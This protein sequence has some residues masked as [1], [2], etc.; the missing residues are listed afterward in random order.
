MKKFFLM[1]LAVVG[2]TMQANAIKLTVVAGDKNDPNNN[3]GCQKLVDGNFA[4]KWGDGISEGQTK[5]IIVKSN[6]AII[7][8]SYV[9]VT[10]NDTGGSPGRNWNVWK[11]YAGN[12]ASDADAARDAEGWVLIDQRADVAGTDQLPAADSQA[13]PSFVL[14]ETVTDSYLYYKIE[15]E[16]C[17]DL[18]TY[19]QMGE[20]YFDSYKV[21][22]SAF[23][24]DIAAANSFDYKKA[25]D[26]LLEAEYET[27]L[28][29]LNASED[30]D[31]VDALLTKIANVKNFINTQA[32]KEFY[33]LGGSNTWGDGGWSNFVDGKYDTKWGGGLG[34]GMWVVFRVRG[35]VQPFVYRLVTGADTKSYWDRNW[36]TWTVY[37]AN[38]KSIS[39]VSENSDQW[40][41]LDVRED[42]GQDLFPAENMNPTTF[43]FTEGVNEPYY[44]FK[45]LVT[46]C[47]NNGG[48]QQMSEIE[49]L[50]KE[51]LDEQK[52]AYL[53]EYA[54]VDLNAAVEPWHEAEKA[55]FVDAYNQL[56]ETNDVL[57]MS[58]LNNTLASLKSALE[59]SIA[60]RAA[61]EERYAN[62]GYL[63]LAGNTAWGNGENW[64]R[65]IDQNNS[66]KWGGGRDQ[67][68]AF[69]IFTKASSMAPTFYTLITG[70]DTAGDPSRN[71]ADWKIY[72]ANFASAAEATRDAEGWVLIDNKEGIGQDLLPGA[73]FAPAY[74]SMS[75][76]D[77]QEYSYFKIEISK[78]FND[79]GNIQMSEF[80]FGTDTE[81]AAIKAG[82]VEE[83]TPFLNGIYAD[84]AMTL[85]YN[86]SLRELT[87]AAPE[88]ILAKVAAVKAVQQEIL[89]AQP[90][91]A[92]VDGVYQI[93]SAGDLVTFA[94]LVNNAE[95]P[96]VGAKAV[97]TA[98]ID[99]TGVP[100]TYI[101]TNGN[102]AGTFDGQGYA[103]KNMTIDERD[104]S[105]IG[106]FKT[107]EGAT[108]TRVKLV[109]AFVNGNNNAGG[110]VGR[111]IN[112][113]ITKC[114]VVDSYVEGRDHVGS[115]AGEIR[116]D[117]GTTF[118]DN[119]SNS[120][121][122]SREYQAGGMIGTILGGLVEHNLFT[123]KVTCVY[124]NGT[125]LVA[126]VDG[127][128]SQSILR[129][130]AIFATSI[131]A[132]DAHSLTNTAGRPCTFQ[133]NYSLDKCLYNGGYFGLTNPDDQ[134]GGQVDWA[135]ATSRAFYSD[136]LGFD[137]AQTWTFNYGG[138]Y[139][140]P[141]YI[142]YD[143]PTK[144]KVPVTTAGY[145]T[146]VAPADV[147]FS[148]AEGV[149]AFYVTDGGS[150]NKKLEPATLVRHGEAVV[151]KAQVEESGETAETGATVE[152]T[153]LTLTN[154][155]VKPGTQTVTIT[156]AELGYSNTDKVGSIEFDGGIITF[157]KGSNS[158]AP[159]Y[160]TSGNA[161]RV[162]GDNTVK[163]TGTKLPIAKV[164]I[165]CGGTSYTGKGYAVTAEGNSL[166]LLHVATSG[167]IRLQ[168]ITIIFADEGITVPY[169]AQDIA[170][171]YAANE[172]KAATEP[173]EADGSQYVLAAKDGVV[174][175]YQAAAG[176]FINRGKGYLEM[177]APTVKV[178]YLTTGDETGIAETMTDE[179]LKADGAI[180][181]LSGRRV[182]KLQKG[183]YIVNG[184]KVVNK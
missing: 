95:T 137:L 173:F 145:A 184:K 25:G 115:I 26:A 106:L 181:D 21:D 77:A 155:D 183:I 22:L 50:T 165:E 10:G 33:A 129:N 53:D 27:L 3:E 9:L 7:P 88:E 90:E 124:T 93:A 116:G 102:Y 123:G 47:Y 157:D 69:L 160:Y 134:N 131:D 161:I 110:I 5:Y 31:E 65:L 44:Y 149:E 80:T 163:F 151:V 158:N 55:S 6:V 132:P 68:G 36:S 143:G 97:L 175:F 135:T 178:Y 130:N 15:I 19:M 71:W 79:G 109:N 74:F 133:N 58:K 40:V 14:T 162:Y 89:A 1:L 41:A 122:Y 28:S 76:K 12:F 60:D 42:I 46:K 153:V 117:V 16:A 82:Y 180:Y 67:S 63:P 103:I 84:E 164:V 4:T 20:F 91:L 113:T 75:E 87:N 114:A 81:L 78:S 18:N 8:T 17:K 49:F 66:S 141:S 34:S 64:T 120:E 94:R 72:G 86:T 96:A 170:E 45:V 70:N 105:E 107:V 85:K 83:F 29:G 154:G 59:T 73:N 148:Q 99:L 11:V 62:G 144:A 179:A 118:T 23:A 38:F 159:T 39:E 138:L 13:T 32:E 108:I 171:P 111:A 147:D 142:V 101:G 167:H 174:G 54:S 24:E 176:S 172:L 156:T 92:E 100:F 2:F 146:F 136:V 152:G 51:Q 121:V 119:F 37:G 104:N 98:D 56:K 166:E 140:T 30:A 52:Q 126:L 43:T 61:Q 169:T 177:A 139:P 150:K 128:E 182:E 35:G 168:T 57:E 48:S 125:G 112:S 127:T